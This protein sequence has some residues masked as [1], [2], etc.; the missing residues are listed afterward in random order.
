MTASPTVKKQLEEGDT[1]DLYNCIRDGG[2]F[3]MNTMNQALEKLVQSKVIT[4]DD[5]IQFAGNQAE[6]RQMLRN[7]K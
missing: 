7:T 6:L 3:G 1:A 2:H 4:Y 5:A